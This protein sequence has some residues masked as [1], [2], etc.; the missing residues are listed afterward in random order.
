MGGVGTPDSGRFQ[1]TAMTL[2]VS[3]VLTLVPAAEP[4][5]EDAAAQARADS[6]AF[7]A[8]L[9]ENKLADSWQKGDPIRMDTEAVRKAYSP[10][11]AY[12]TFSSIPLGGGAFT[13][14]TQKAYQQAMEEYRKNSLSIAVLINDGKVTALTKPADFN[15]GLLPIKTDEDARTAAAAIMSLQPAG[16]IGPQ[17]VEP[18]N[19]KVMKDKG[20]TCTCRLGGGILG[21]G[22]ARVTFDDE[23]RCTSVTMPRLMLPRPPA[24]PPRPTPPPR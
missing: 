22:E 15:T 4:A 17:R 1:E 16:E 21:G 12:Y 20:W 2:L 23:G 8:F 13:K 5:K 7:R 14:E 9:K 24:T 18:K 19:V 10:Y 6:A 3:M 11:R